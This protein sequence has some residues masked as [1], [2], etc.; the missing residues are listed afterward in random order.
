VHPATQASANHYCNR[1]ISRKNRF[2][3]SDERMAEDLFMS[4]EL[5][6]EL[7]L[8]VQQLHASPSRLLGGAPL[9]EPELRPQALGGAVYVYELLTHPTATKCYAWAAPSRGRSTVMH[10]VLHSGAITSPEAAVRSL[11][12]KR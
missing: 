3:D 1:C 9:S 2:T 6:D 11:R 10:A 12:R 8:A 7:R 4:E 5:A